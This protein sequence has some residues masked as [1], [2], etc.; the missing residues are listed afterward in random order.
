MSSRC[1]ICMNEMPKDRKGIEQVCPSCR[2]GGFLELY[3]PEYSYDKEQDWLKFCKGLVK[4]HRE[5]GMF[6]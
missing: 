3:N 4:Y 2:Q 1:R 5:T 6:S